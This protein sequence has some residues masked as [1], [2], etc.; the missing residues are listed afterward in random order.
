M[1]ISLG[2][3]M[4]VLLLR[5]YV[6][7]VCVLVLGALP[8]RVHADTVPPLRIVAQQALLM[9]SGAEREL[10]VRLRVRDAL[11]QARIILPL[12]A[13]ATATIWPDGAPLL[14]YAATVSGA[15]T[16]PD[17]TAEALGY[18]L[19]PFTAPSTA[20]DGWL[21]QYAPAL[22]PDEHAALT[23]HHAAGGTLLA[24]RLTDTQATG[25]LIPL[26]IQY[27][28]PAQIPAHAPTMRAVPLDLFVLSTQRMTA[29]EL[30]T[31]FAMPLAL[32][33]LPAPHAFAAYPTITYLTHL[34][35][36]SSADVRL[37]SAAESNEP[38]AASRSPR[39]RPTT[40][41][42]LSLIF[43]MSVL[44]LSMAVGLR[45]RFDAISPET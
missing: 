43:C 28:A 17:A 42:G 41:I 11:P 6:G 27:T 35:G 12:P 14:D 25:D 31:R 32:L 2:L 15:A 33:E 5:W 29:P 13:E 38:V 39:T 1:R 10:I 36:R 16:P 40:M 37:L 22:T 44:A 18:T 3:L 45:R 8:V 23:A 4:R 26:R 7:L 34:S 19:T 21:T 24:L 30:R 20:L 9:D